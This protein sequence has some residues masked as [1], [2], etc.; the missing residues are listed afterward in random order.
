MGKP[1][2]EKEKNM[3]LKKVLAVLMTSAM[4]MGMS[5]TTFATPVT[6]IISDITITGLASNAVTTV[7]G[8]Q[9]A[10]LD[11]NA[12][13]NEYSWIIADWATDYVE[14]NA[15]G[16]AYEIKDGQ[17][18][19][20]K[21]AAME[22]E[23][24]LTET[25]TLQTTQV[26]FEDA[27]IGGYVFVPTDD[28]ATYDEL[29]VVNTYN[30]VDSP[31]DNKP[32]PEDVTAVAKMQTHTITKEQNDDFVQI[33]ETVD[34]TVKTTFP[35]SKDSDGNPLT[36]F[37]VTD[38]PTGL[39]IEASTVKV[40]IGGSSVTLPGGA[41]SVDG[42]GKLTVDFASQLTN[43]YDG[44]E[45][46]ITYTATV[47]NTDYNNS[48]DASSNVTDY[49]GDSVE[50]EN[51][52][53]QIT[54]VDAEDTATVLPG[55]EFEI[56]DLGVG[57]VWNAEEPGTPM[58]LVYDSDLNA[59]RPALADESG[60]TTIIDGTSGD[61]VANG[62]IKVVGLAEGNYHFVE[63]KAPS[64]YSI[65]EAGLTVTINPDEDEPTIDISENFLDTKLSSLPS[66]GGIGTTIF[67][68]GGCT[69]MIAAAGLYFAS[70]RKESK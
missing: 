1:K 27:P 23:V 41:I 14:L 50:G 66:T 58:N 4:V 44:R 43:G 26:V 55:V 12:E 24:T 33:G 51:G 54:K 22:Q 16:T 61:G 42:E 11:Y 34:Y 37:K 64:G 7:N 56:Y 63:T 39:Q 28:V 25:D 65:N 45:V 18:L 60:T 47:T 32:V 17:E 21:N 3:K 29:F 13:T 40:T 6:D 36:E 48:V 2:K 10:S 30:R 62:I 57:G 67:T 8:Y 9:F 20:F 70:R 5:V 38:T 49:D 69:I 46:V 68:V 53:I 31:T 35:V 15:N 52:S 19:N 59:Y